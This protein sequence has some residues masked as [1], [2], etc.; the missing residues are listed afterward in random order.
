MTKL[1]RP[2]RH[3]HLSRAAI[4]RVALEIADEDGVEG[5]NLRKVAAKLGVGTMTLYR[6]VPDRDA[7]VDDVVGLLLSEVDTSERSGERWDETIRRVTRS[8]HEMALR[9]PLAC[10]LVALAPEDQTPVLEHAR[11]VERLHAKQHIPEDVFIKMW[12]VVD[13]FS[14]GFILLEAKSH[15]GDRED[16]AM[17]HYRDA[18][19]LA[20]R[21]TEGQTADAFNEGL[22]VIIAGLRATLMEEPSPPG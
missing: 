12:S 3:F 11:K 14:T 2:R 6:Y 21:L 9:H 17:A 18:Q 7:M 20:S 8:V 4:A 22:E 15:T 5:V 1:V 16:E 13:A 10:E 19:S